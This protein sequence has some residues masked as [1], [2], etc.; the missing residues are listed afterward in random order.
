MKAIWVSPSNRCSHTLTHSISPAERA[1][2][3][4]V[5]SGRVSAELQISA[6]AAAVERCF[7]LWKTGTRNCPTQSDP[8]VLLLQ[9]PVSDSGQTS[10]WNRSRPWGKNS[11]ENTHDRGP[12]PRPPPPPCPPFSSCSVGRK[13]SMAIST[14]SALSVGGLGDTVLGNSWPTQ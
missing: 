7:V 2:S 13:V 14:P 6:R 1:M 9:R 4:F 8:Q 3:C 12:V 10:V 5:S 11:L